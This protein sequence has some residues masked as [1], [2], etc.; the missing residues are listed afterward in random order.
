LHTSRGSPVPCNRDRTCSALG[1][2]VRQSTSDARG[3]DVSANAAGR[4]DACRHASRAC[5]EDDRQAPPQKVKGQLINLFKAGCLP[6]QPLLPPCSSR[7]VGK[8]QGTVTAAA[9]CQRLA[10]LPRAHV[11]ASGR[12][13]LSSLPSDCRARVKLT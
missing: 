2:T 8:V 12:L 6:F 4:K 11:P 13:P 9:I 10:Q 1:Y 5:L 7:A 3:C